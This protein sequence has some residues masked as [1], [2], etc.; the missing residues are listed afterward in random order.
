MNN[1]LKM[2]NHRFGAILLTILLS[3]ISHAAMA[4]GTRISG[5][6]S[7]EMGPVMMANVVERDGN[8][9]IINA[10]TTDFNGNFALAIKS[11]KNKL[12]ISYVGNK[13]VTL[14]LNGKQRVFKVF[15]ESETQL[16][17]VV[18]KAVKKTDVGGLSIPVKE[19]TVAT[20]TFNMED[21][22]GL[23]FTS[24]DEALQGEI[25]GLDIVSN[26]GNLGA[27]TQMRLRGVTTI[28]G[29]ANPLIVVDDKIFDNPDESF[30]FATASE[31]QYASLLSVNVDDI[32][33]IDVLKDAAATAVWGAYGA[34]GVIQ[35]TTKRG[36][37]GKTKVNLSYKFTGTWMPKGYKLLN[38]DQY[39]MMLKEEFYNQTQSSS[40]TTSMAE[41]NYDKS[42]AEYENWN[43]NTDW[44]KEVSDFGK[45]HNINLN[46][47]GGGEKATFRIS[48]SYDNQTGTII[49]QRLDRLTTRLVLDYN[50]SDRIRFSTNFA[51]TYTN[52][53]KNYTDLLSIAQRLAPNMAIYRQDEFGNDTDEYY[54]MNPNAQNKTPYDGNY[55]SWNLR[56]QRSLGNPVAIANLAWKK[57]KTYR[58]NPDFNLKYELLGKDPDQHR[59]TLSADVDFDI[60]SN[61][62]PTWY[63][64][65]LSTGNNTGT[66]WQNASYNAS[67][68][69]ES[70]RFQIGAEGKLTFTPHFNN[71]DWNASA[72]LRYQMHTSKSNSQYIGI[73]GLP[74]GITSPT[75][76]G[77]LSSMSK[78]T[79]RAADENIMFNAHA[80]YKSIYNLG[81]S[82]RMDGSSKFGKAHKWASFPGLSARYNISDEKFVRSWLPNLI[83]LFGIRASWGVNGRPPKDNYLSY[84][85]YNTN[86]GSYGKSGS[87]IASGTLE[88]LKLDDL[89]WEKTTSINIGANLNLFDDRLTI[90]FDYYRKNTSDLLMEGVKIPTTTGYSALAWYNVG[91]MTN[92]GWELN[93][94]GRDFIKIGKKF[95]ISATFNIAQNVNNIKQM[96]S[97]VL[98]AMNKTWDDVKAPNGSTLYLERI[99]ENNPLGSIYGYKF[100]GVYQ[101]SYSYLEN[102]RKEQE[103]AYKAEGKVYTPEMYQDWINSQIAEG[104]TFPVVKDANGQVVMNNNGTPKQIVYNYTTSDDG[105]GGSATYAFKGGDAIYEDIN[106]DGQI[107][108]LD[109]VYLGNSMPKFNG[110]FSLTFK[111]GRWK[112]VARFNYRYGNKIVNLARANLE[113]M[114]TT[115]NQAATVNYRW[116][117][118]GDVTPIPRAIY[119][120][121]SNYNYFGSSKYVED[122]SFLR[123]QNLQISYSLPQKPLKKI[124]LSSLSLYFSVNNIYCWTNYSGVDPEVSYG[125]Y[126]I[127]YDTSKTPRSRTFTASVSVGF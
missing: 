6:V 81:F 127:A 96:D 4:Q 39:T 53:Q 18:V 23:A 14:P 77:A 51:L 20:Q 84:E 37:R 60:Y 7:D 67:T 63:P 115:N 110:G 28:N 33:K 83:S 85:K 88:K 103:I 69:S 27:G 86:A 108:A 11:P 22:E 25:A 100:K 44:V 74:S 104:K 97:R 125:A 75:V 82:M 119:G 101:Y 30:D 87:T 124:G 114:L 122:G 90:D 80:S 126:G 118:D 29:D 48:G 45:L 102:Y 106:N 32:A 61:S 52:N 117:K 66:G 107:N 79:S 70:N 92:N 12:V 13:T 120:T 24:A 57:E 109:I 91:E 65:A 112:L 73:A 15:M 59:L 41:I 54:Y 55:S 2:S 99:Q 105:S 5:T 89:R 8:N 72:L 46:I 16:Q 56:D 19:M 36:I 121:G 123:F 98:E 116:R 49:K 68:S 9:R 94:S 93:I 76:D 17:E 113:N 1:I 71:E 26:S 35:I 78:G 62:S 50:V 40:A 43:N 111:Y 64:A 21:V 42:W 31:E 34:N 58:I 47:T 38:G 3:M 95:S 10:T